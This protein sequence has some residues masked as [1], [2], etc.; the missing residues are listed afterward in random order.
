VFGRVLLFVEF[1]VF[2]ALPRKNAVSLDV[3][4]CSLVRTD[5][6]EE[7]IAYSFRIGR[8]RDQGTALEVGWQNTGL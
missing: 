3:P 5:D 6:L 8:I 2:T 1:E 4:P 7:R